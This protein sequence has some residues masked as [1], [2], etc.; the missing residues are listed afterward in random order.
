MWRGYELQSETQ[1]A[2]TVMYGILQ[3]PWF[4]NR[5]FS[6]AQVPILSGQAARIILDR[7]QDLLI[8]LKVYPCIRDGQPSRQSASH[9]EYRKK[10]T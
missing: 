6:N 10:A 7:G 2:A 9:L 4:Q 3:A 1:T 5:G 8:Q